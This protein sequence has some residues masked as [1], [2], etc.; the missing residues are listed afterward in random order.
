LAVTAVTGSAE[1]CGQVRETEG[2]CEHERQEFGSPMRESPPR[3]GSH[4][5][6]EREREG[7]RGREGERERGR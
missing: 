5:E 2:Q 3:K 1:T 7:E 6:R 4:R